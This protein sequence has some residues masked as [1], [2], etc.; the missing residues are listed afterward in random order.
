[1]IFH[2]QLSLGQLLAIVLSGRPVIVARLDCTAI[3]LYTKPWSCQGSG[4][5]S[6]SRTGEEVIRYNAPAQRM[7]FVGFCFFVYS[8]YNT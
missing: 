2:L 5:I 1:M 3:L 8:M 4:A 6:L 7:E